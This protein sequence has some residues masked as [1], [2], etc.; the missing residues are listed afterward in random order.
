MAKE[1]ERKFL[2][3]SMGFVHQ[4]ID[5]RPIRQGFLANDEKKTVR[6]RSGKDKATLTIKG[7]VKGITR[8]EHDIDISIPL[9]NSILD[10]FCPVKMSKTRYVVENEGHR[11]EVDIFHGDNEG[12]MIA[13]IELEHEDEE[14]HRPS[15]IGKEV[16]LDHR[17]YNSE[18]IKNPYKNWK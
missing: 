17:Y 5:K 6:V 3:R 10:E 16:S 11:W 2:V 18:L 12:L 1:I 7:E 9:A 4:A 8:T 15:W 13:E 14:F